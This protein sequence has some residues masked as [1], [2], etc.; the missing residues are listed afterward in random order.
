MQQ[1]VQA[2]ATVPLG[3]IAKRTADVSVQ[4]LHAML[5]RL[6]LSYCEED[7]VRRDLKMQ[8]APVARTGA[9]VCAIHSESISRAQEAC[10]NKPQASPLSEFRATCAF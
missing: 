6:S 10:R 8:R 5:V 2:S 4:D 7:S 3:D 1:P 9:S